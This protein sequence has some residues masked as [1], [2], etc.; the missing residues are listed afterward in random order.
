VLTAFEGLE[1]QMT[2]RLAFDIAA[3]QTAAAGTPRDRQIAVG[4]TYNLGRVHF[5]R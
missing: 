3:Q 4:L 5:T 2:E 1:Y